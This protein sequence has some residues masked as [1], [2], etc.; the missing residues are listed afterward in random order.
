MYQ[1]PSVKNFIA[2]KTENQNPTP[3]QMHPF[4]IDVERRYLQV[5][6]AHLH[7]YEDAKQLLRRTKKASLK[8]PVEADITINS[9]NNPQ[10]YAALRLNKNAPKHTFDV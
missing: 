10:L 6:E 3:D 8:K 5:L 4:L 9:F 2:K 1:L 7:V